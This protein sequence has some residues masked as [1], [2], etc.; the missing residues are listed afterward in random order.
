MIESIL[1]IVALLLS[2][3]VVGVGIIIAVLWFSVDKD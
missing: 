3:A 2:G 1:I